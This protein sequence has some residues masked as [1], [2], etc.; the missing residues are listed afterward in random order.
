M[1][2]FAKKKPTNP[3]LESLKTQISAAKAREISYVIFPV[4]AQDTTRIQ[5]ER[6]LGSQGYAWQFSHQCQGIYY[7]N[8][9]T[10]V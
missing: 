9:K 6:W 1:S 8:I 5:V 2:L 4:P 7:Y 10:G 3:T